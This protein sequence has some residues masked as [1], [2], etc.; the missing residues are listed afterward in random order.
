MKRR[1]KWYILERLKRLN[2]LKTELNRLV[3][4]SIFKNTYNNQIQSVCAYR[5]IYFKKIKY[6]T[7]SNF[8]LYCMFNISP[9]LVNKKFRLSRFSFN[10]L[11]K[12]ANISK[13]VKIG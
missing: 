12:N 11:A 6:N 9:K 7:I 4:K 8:R 3:G 10:R 1:A 2:F 5:Y 13:L